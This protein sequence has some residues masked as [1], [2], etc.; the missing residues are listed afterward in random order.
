MH[1]LGLRTT[2]YPTQD[3]VETTRIFR[4]LLGIEPY[5]EEDFYV[6]FNV[7]GYELGIDPNS[8][9]DDGTQ[10]YWGVDDIE[11]AAEE[12]INDGAEILAEVNEVGDG[13][14]VAQFRLSDGNHFAI[15][16]NPN[17]ELD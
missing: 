5:F 12:L 15:I 6:G 10:S 16:E 3:L 1:L 2:I 14:K 13:I 7:G 9:L 11:A 17:F 4:G 8:N